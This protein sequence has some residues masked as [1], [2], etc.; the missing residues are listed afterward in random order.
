MN[1]S[2]SLGSCGR[3]VP[4][5]SWP[6]EWQPLCRELLVPPD[7]SIAIDGA[8][9]SLFAECHDIRRRAGYPTRLPPDWQVLADHLCALVPVIQDDALQFTSR[10][11]VLP[12]HDRRRLALLLA[13]VHAQV[14]VHALR[15][16]LSEFQ[17]VCSDG[18]R[19]A[20]A[21]PA[22]DEGSPPAAVQPVG[23]NATDL[24]GTITTLAMCVRRRRQQAGDDLRGED[25]GSADDEHA[26]CLKKPR[27]AH[28]AKPAS[29]TPP[30]GD[31]MLF[32]EQHRS[33]AE[34][35][36]ATAEVGIVPL[37]PNAERA[38][39][40]QRKQQREQ[41]QP[42]A[43]SAAMLSCS[44]T[45]TVSGL[46]KPRHKHLP[47]SDVDSHPQLATLAAPP[48]L[49]LS[50]LLDDFLS[51]NERATFTDLSVISTLSLN[52]VEAFLSFVDC[53]SLSEAVVMAVVQQLSTMPAELGVSVSENVCS[54]LVLPK[55]LSLAQLASRS[56]HAG[57][58]QL[59]GRYPRAAISSVLIPAFSDPASAGGFQCELVRRLVRDVLDVG[60]R[61]SV[62]SGFLAASSRLDAATVWTEDQISCFQTLVEAKVL[63]D[64][65]AC[66]HLAACL[67]QQAP[68]QAKN[69]KFAK[70]FLAIVQKYGPPMLPHVGTLQTAASASTTFLKKPLL[71]AIKKLG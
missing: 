9:Q 3:E 50:R 51:G 26:P 1:K 7:E 10:L 53:A 13:R 67:G 30:A 24:T 5:E 40:M 65:E 39:P 41:Q 25:L 44:Q 62:A 57:L 34:D 71:A 42:M 15:A 14:P 45:S 48:K 32:E 37:A 11:R 12:E 49:A 6:K 56:L 68:L 19:L 52:Q 46:V 16:L 21:L 58:V 33:P 47:R 22:G 60:Q 64:A 18:C 8:V 59:L 54:A 66:S 20:A 70:L 61:E 4:V 63:M 35:A 69:L 29:S 38:P 43:D 23:D 17:H 31:V 28:A 2:G 55:V 36:G 27:L